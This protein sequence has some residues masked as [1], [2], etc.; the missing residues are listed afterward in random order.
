MSRVSTTGLRRNLAIAIGNAGGLVP[1]TSLE[2]D[3]DDRER[4]SLAD[5]AVADAIAW[6]RARL[7]D[8]DS[9]LTAPGVGGGRIMDP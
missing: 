5:P 9:A 7:A 2:V 6:A 4:P 3:A 8:G 1:A